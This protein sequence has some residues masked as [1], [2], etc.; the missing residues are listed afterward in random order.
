[1]QMLNRQSGVALITVL[2]VV[3]LLTALV[4]HLMVHQSLVLAKSTQILRADKA[5]AYAR[6]GETFARQILFD[7]WN[8][9]GSRE[10]DSLLETW[11]QSAEPLELDE[12]FLELS[13]TDMQGRFNLNSLAGENPATNLDKFKRL[14]AALNV[15]P[16]LADTWRDWIDDDSTL[17]GFGAEDADYLS[18]DP[19]YRTA[20]QPAYHAS[21]LR[22]IKNM[23][24]D[25]YY[26]ILP[27]VTV[28]PIPDFRININTASAETLQSVTT[29]MTPSKAQSLVET[30]RDYHTRRSV[31]EEF[32][33]FNESADALTVRSEFF[34]I[35]VRVEIDEG[36]V[37]LT[38]LVYRDLQTGELTILNRDYSRRFAGRQIENYAQTDN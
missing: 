20:N 6:G 21:E 36:R 27:H 22:L 19:P 23:D 1:M 34:E 32:P 10:H 14:L 12:G 38:S 37:E 18:S 7:D 24:K 30:E 29:K 31:L 4:Y 8:E 25:T 16:G 5:I 17:A 15:E 9:T 35:Q 11:A 28:L 3:A 2:L 26:T 33:E 13:I